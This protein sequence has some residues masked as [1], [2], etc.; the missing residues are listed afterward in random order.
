MLFRKSLLSRASAD[1]RT[2]LWGITQLLALHLRPSG[3]CLRPASQ[4]HLKLI[5]LLRPA[6]GFPYALRLELYDM[7]TQL[8]SNATEVQC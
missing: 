1:R 5:E 2:G 7:L 4:E 8:L 3:S 6:F